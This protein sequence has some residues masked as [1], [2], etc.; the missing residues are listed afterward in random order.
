[1]SLKA[2][3]LLLLICALITRS[4]GFVI[5][6]RSVSRR[7]AI[8]PLKSEPLTSAQ[9]SDPSDF[10]VDVVARCAE[11]RC[12]PVRT[13]STVALSFMA[14]CCA[15]LR[16]PSDAALCCVHGVALRCAVFMALRCVALH[17]SSAALRVPV[18]SAALRVPVNSAALRCIPLIYK[19]RNNELSSLLKHNRFGLL[20]RM[21]CSVWVVKSL[22][23]QSILT[24]LK[25]R[26]R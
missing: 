23:P 15:A 2:V 1:M 25:R 5:G 14:W 18:N 22:R 19:Q 4:F 9:V 16:V 13:L 8:S 3:F 17:S 7:S 24:L 21:L 6:G 10:G 26:I 20:R 12:I 11:L